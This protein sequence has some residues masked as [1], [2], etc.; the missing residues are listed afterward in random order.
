[1]TLQVCVVLGNPKPGSRTLTVAVE[2]AR[3]LLGSA[4]HSFRVI[5]LAD[6]SDRVFSWPS[7]EMA[8]LNAVVAESDLVIFGSPTYKA[9]YTGLLKAFLDRYPTNGLQGVVAIPV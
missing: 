5:D 3:A 4:E 8:E 7:D 9:T 2:L 1:M 6:Y